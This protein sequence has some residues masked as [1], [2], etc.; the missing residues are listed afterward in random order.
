MMGAQG[1]GGTTPMS[2]RYGWNCSKLNTDKPVGSVMYNLLDL[3][4]APQLL[5]YSAV[6]IETHREHSPA[7]SHRGTSELTT[8][9]PL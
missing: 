5:S 1:L 8:N 9:L 6:A 3:N 4:L 7:Q 2:H